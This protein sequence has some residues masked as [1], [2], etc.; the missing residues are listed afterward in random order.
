LVKRAKGRVVAAAV[1]EAPAR[2]RAAAVV[3]EAPARARAAAVVSVVPASARV[4]V[5]N[6]AELGD[7]TRRLTASPRKCLALTVRPRWSRAVAGSAS[8]QW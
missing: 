4:A 6:A 5:A 1:S 8:V 2:A 7:T 3:S